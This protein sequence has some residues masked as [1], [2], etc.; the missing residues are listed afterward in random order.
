VSG[1]V[2]GQGAAPLTQDA[3]FCEPDVQDAVTRAAETATAASTRSNKAARRMLVW[4]MK[5]LP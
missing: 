5:P 3:A 2:S 4:D 1:G